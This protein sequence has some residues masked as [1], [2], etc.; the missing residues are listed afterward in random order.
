MR[1][2]RLP[3][4]SAAAGVRPIRATTAAAVLPALAAVFVASTLALPVRA[5]AQEGVE[6]CWSGTLARDGLE[7]DV[8]LDISTRNGRTAATLDMDALWIAG[9]ALPSFRTA[10]QSVTFELPWS[11]G[12]FEGTLEGGTV[13][14]RV[15]FSDEGTAP[16]RLEA[17]R[18]RTRRTVDLRWESGSA[19]VA[20]TLALPPRPGPHPVV[21]ILHG[22]GDSSRE[23]SPYAFWGHY[24]PRHGIAALL[25]D[26]RG[27]G[28]STGDWHEVGFRERARDVTRG[29]DLVRERPDVDG[30]RVG[31][32]GVSQGSWVAGLAASMDPGVDFVVHVSGPAVPVLEADT[33]A[34]ESR[35]RRE[36]WE[37]RAAAERLR[38]WRLNARV[39]R[40]PSSDEAWE[41]LQ[42]AIDEVRDRPWFRE[43]PYEPERESEW[44][45]WYGRVLD[46]DPRPVLDELAIPMLWIYGAMDGQSDPSRNVRIL[47]DYRR[48]GKEYTIGLYPEAGH[49]LLVPVDPRGEQGPHLTTAPGF[50]PDLI[51]WLRIRVETP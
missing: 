33:Y 7:W 27:N 23:S 38:L 12:S 24:L 22:G 47:E 5:T 9:R 48:S 30:S 3:S 14:G 10:D 25:Y 34:T 49:G 15:A 19:V 36:G 46:H 45:G 37:E 50:F 18:C 43:D 41:E 4:R 16:L 1:C 6:G 42:A 51:R 17:V 2:S 31:L 35:L 21:A 44:R 8:G 20:G 13:A 26:K 29:L 40:H 11:L 39:A 28:E 32:L